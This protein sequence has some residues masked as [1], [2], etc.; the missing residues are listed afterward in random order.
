VRLAAIF[1]FCVAL[2][3][4]ANRSPDSFVT[5]CDWAGEDERGVRICTEAIASEGLTPVQQAL[6][7]SDRG[8]YYIGLGRYD[9]AIADLTRSIEL[10][11]NV[12]GTFQRRSLAHRW[13][14]ENEEAIRDLDRA[15]ALKPD[16]AYAYFSRG[17]AY[18]DLEKYDEALDSYDQA[19][20]I[21]PKLVVAYNSRGH[22]HY[23]LKQW[24]LA[25]PE[26]KRAIEIDPKFAPGHQNLA[27]TYVELGEYSLAIAE[28]DRALAIEPGNV[29][30]HAQRAIARAWAGDVDGAL[31]D[32]EE[33]LADADGL[34]DEPGGLDPAVF[35]TKI[36]FLRGMIYIKRADYPAAIAAFGD[37]IEANPR[38]AEA[39]YLRA[40]AYRLA[41]DD[42]KADADCKTA[43]ELD[44][45]IDE[46][47]KTWFNT[48]S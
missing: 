47:M 20:K 14:S 13:K 8:H 24:D 15:I 11:P 2:V 5:N 4:C 6:V 29:F 30:I 16:Y 17:L 18:F 23:T 36:R 31:A 40:A 22:T 37:A 43:L 3:G 35:K 21:D 46:R 10:N 33:F 27:T 26:Y 1:V 28:Y 12:A 39:Y 45:G 19:I 44:P 48:S 25:V 7:L 34:K 32:A 42:G 9:E 38:S 41:G